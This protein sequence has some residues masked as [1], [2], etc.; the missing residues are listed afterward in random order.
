MLTANEKAKI[1]LYLGWPAKTIIED[2]TDYSKTFS[3]RLEN[4]NASFESE[5]RTLLTKILAVDTCLDEAKNRL[6]AKQVGDIQTNE[7]EMYELKKERKRLVKILS[8]ILDLEIIS[9]GSNG[10]GICI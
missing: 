8:G 7:A 10:I 9:S 1:V 6:G 3:D 5:I 2:S 4:F